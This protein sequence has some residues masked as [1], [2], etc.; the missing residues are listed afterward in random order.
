MTLW[1]EN[2]EGI[3]VTLSEI[4]RGRQLNTMTSSGSMGGV[5]YGG[6]NTTATTAPGG[7]VDQPPSTST[8]DSMGAAT[9][10]AIYNR[11]PMPPPAVP[12]QSHNSAVGAQPSSMGFQNRQANMTATNTTTA[13]S[14]AH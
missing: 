9:A 14:T 3:W 2:L 13:T 6:A 12:L 8:R 4:A 5:G 10:A 7:A 11:A 1:K